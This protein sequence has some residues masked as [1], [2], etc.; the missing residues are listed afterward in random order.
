MINTFLMVLLCVLSSSVTADYK[1]ATKNYCHDQADKKEFDDLLRKH[2]TDTGIIRLLA[3]RQGLCEMID[4]QQIP[5]ETGIELWAIERQK[6]LMER[7]KEELN[8][9]SKKRD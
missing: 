5:L 9:L 1:E 4:K 7:T 8:R 3:M 6:A 2:P